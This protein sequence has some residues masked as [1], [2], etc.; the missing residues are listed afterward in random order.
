MMN[1][2]AKR[3]ISLTLSWTSIAVFSLCSGGTG[4]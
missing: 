3:V 1:I 2:E 4:G